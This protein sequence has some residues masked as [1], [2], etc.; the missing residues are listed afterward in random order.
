VIED[1]LPVG[2][3]FATIGNALKSPPILLQHGYIT[4]TEILIDGKQCTYNILYSIDQARFIQNENAKSFELGPPFD[5]VNSEDIVN[6]EVLVGT[7]GKGYIPEL[8]YKALDVY[9]QIE[10]KLFMAGISVLYRPHPNEDYADYHS[11]FNKIDKRSTS[12]CISGPKK[13]F[14]GYVSTLFFEAKSFGHGIIAIINPKE[15]T[16][17]Y[18]PDF[19]INA[20][21]IGNPEQVVLQIQKQLELNNKTKFL[22]LE[23]RFKGIIRELH[24]IMKIIGN[25]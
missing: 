17:A 25:R 5:I 9:M 6:E 8:Y 13:I 16:L 22:S 20:N 21:D 4:G 11:K 3:F 2:S 24:F 19:E 14:I 23:E 18:K 7:G 1:T 12:E 10:K 15:P